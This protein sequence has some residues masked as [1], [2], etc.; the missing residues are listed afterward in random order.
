MQL[1][2]LEY[3]VILARERHFGAAARACGISQSALSQALR[4]VEQE[5]GAPIVIRRNQGF[6]A[7]TAEGERV[8]EWA[9]S[10]LADHKTLLQQIAG[11]GPGSLS[12]HL[13]LGVIPVA[14]PMVSLI[15]SPF[16]RLYPDVTISLRSHNSGQILRGLERFELEAGIT[17][18]DHAEHTS[19]RP[20]VLYNE[21]YHLLA[22]RAHPVAAQSSVTWREVADLPL[23]L[24]SPDMLNRVLLESIF[25]SAGVSPK[26]VIDTD[27][28]MLLCSHVRSGEWFTIVPH[29]FF[30]V[31][32]GWGG[33]KALPIV[34]PEATNTMGL[35]VAER[36]PMPPL[37]NAFVEVLQTLDVAAELRK[38]VV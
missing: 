28:A 29:S 16:R 11:A 1:R 24:L 12:G 32:D 15:T 33:T 26:T 18:L 37:I 2:Q 7:F 38:Y 36:S 25:Q 35:L 5:F 4:T 3:L 9:R 14:T 23:C 8:L 13:R 21:T 17:Y 30:Y 6:Q 34:E 22:P 31:I 20:Y 19:L 27:C 10:V